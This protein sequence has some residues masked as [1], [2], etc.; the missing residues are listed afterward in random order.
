MLIFRQAAF[1][2]L[3]LLTLAH[4]VCDFVLQSDR[5]AKEKVPGSDLTL[6]WQWWLAAHASTHGLA[7]AL[8]TGYPILGVAETTAHAGIDWL[9]GRF[10]FALA[11]DQSMHLACK[12]LWVVLIF[13]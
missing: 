6:S 13:R 12:A 9:K 11:L 5:M 2:S 10:R 4:F 1:D 8:I 7:V 3:I